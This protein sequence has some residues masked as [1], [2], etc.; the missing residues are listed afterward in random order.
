MSSLLSWYTEYS[1]EP[2]PGL[3]SQPDAVLWAPEHDLPLLLVEVDLHTESPPVLVAKLPKYAALSPTSPKSPTP[4]RAAA[5]PSWSRPGRRSS[6][7]RCA[8][9]PPIRRSRSS[10][11]AAA[12]SA[13]WR[14]ATGCGG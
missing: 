5:G 6:M 11:A 8:S 13:G 10:S 1:I 3:K 12:A 2:R 9:G 14:S 4:P 7:S